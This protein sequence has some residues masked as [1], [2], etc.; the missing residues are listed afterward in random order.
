MKSF[1]LALFLIGCNDYNV[2]RLIYKKK[3]MLEITEDISTKHRLLFN[4]TVKD[5]GITLPFK[6]SSMTSLK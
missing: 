1:N 5:E 2:A 3:A 6:I 4:F